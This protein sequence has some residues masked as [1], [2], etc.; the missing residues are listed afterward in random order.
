MEYVVSK[1]KNELGHKQQHEIQVCQGGGVVPVMPAITGDLKQKGHY[2]EANQLGLHWDSN[3]KSKW[4]N[5]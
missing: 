1:Y 2:S 4:I 3:L 5:K